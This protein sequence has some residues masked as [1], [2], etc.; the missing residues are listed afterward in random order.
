[1]PT[2]R[3]PILLGWDQHGFSY[4]AAADGFVHVYSNWSTRLG[5]FCRLRDWN[6]MLRWNPSFRAVEA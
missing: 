4:W 3:P 1:M 6:H 2:D 5:S